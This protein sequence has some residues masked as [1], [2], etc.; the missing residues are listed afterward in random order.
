MIP[1]ES[2]LGWNGPFQRAFW[3]TFQMVEMPEK[4]FSLVYILD[5][6]VFPLWTEG[7]GIPLY[8]VVYNLGHCVTDDQ[9][10]YALHCSPL[11]KWYESLRCL[12]GMHV[13][14]GRLSW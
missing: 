3:H 13:E 9:D 8:D 5:K 12:Q 10:V 11:N 7:M 4:A 1:Q 2:S 6:W 14:P